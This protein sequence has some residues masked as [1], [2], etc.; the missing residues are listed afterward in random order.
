LVDV[1]ENFDS[2][3][4]PES[5]PSRRTSDTYYASENFCLRAHTSAHQFE[6][7]KK[8]LDNFLIVGDV[9]RR[10]EIDKVH[11][12]LIF[13]IVYFRHIFLAFIKLKVLFFFRN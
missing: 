11:Y 13:Y 1:F 10:D 5:H 2:L 3:L 8:G 9:Y 7:L 4:I 6:L 12:L